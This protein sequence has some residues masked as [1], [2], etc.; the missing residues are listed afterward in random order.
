MSFAFSWP[1]AFPSAFYETARNNLEQ[2]MNAGSKL[3]LA[4]D[5]ILVQELHLGTI[6]PELDLLEINQLSI[7]GSFSGSFFLSYNGNAYISL[8]THLHVNPLS[9]ILLSAAKMMVQLT[10][11]QLR[12]RC[13]ISVAFS[14]ASGLTLVFKDDPLESLNVSSSFD[15]IGVISVFLQ[16][17]IENQLRERFRRDLPTLIHKLS[18]RWVA[19][20]N[21]QPTGGPSAP[22][23]VERERGNHSSGSGTDTDTDDGG[24]EPD[25]DWEPDDSLLDPPPHSQYYGEGEEERSMRAP[26]PAVSS[27][28][29]LTLSD[30]EEDGGDE[31][32][33]ASFSL[34][35]FGAPTSQARLG[36]T[37]PRK[38]GTIH[39][40]VLASSPGGDARRRMPSAGS[41]KQS[42][43][44]RPRQP[45]GTSVTSPHLRPT[46]VLHSPI[47]SGSAMGSSTGHASPSPPVNAGSSNSEEPRQPYAKTR[48]PS[49]SA[50]S[51]PR[52]HPTERIRSTSASATTSSARA[53]AETASDSPILRSL[54]SHRQHFATTFSNPIE[55]KASTTG[56]ATGTGAGA[57]EDQADSLPDLASLLGT[58]PGAG[59]GADAG[60]SLRARRRRIHRLDTP[61]PNT[62]PQKHGANE[63]GKG[64]STGRVASRTGDEN[65]RPRVASFRQ[66]DFDEY[67]PV[68]GRDRHVEHTHLPTSASASPVSRAVP[69]H[70]QKQQD[71][72]GSDRAAAAAGWGEGSRQRS[73]STMKPGLRRNMMS[74]RLRDPNFFAPNYPG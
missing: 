53:E 59:A 29:D 74:S 54:Q 2:A 26:S 56:T 5:R 58:S 65:A 64:R 51:A 57:N 23:T 31:G 12:L 21:N 30:E 9:S 7:D 1:R 33:A 27:D 63:K 28:S 39:A 55:R 13:V 41:P 38:E 48:S 68:S 37:P 8:V 45:S 47:A 22:I 42:P 52:R 69:V 15:D 34:S 35:G 20:I 10:L 49:V 61:S 66:A 43:L 50:S 11:S 16:R 17:E 19:D 72:F 3:P 18:Q 14:K 24:R 32:R 62:S 25:S 71:A 70:K 60:G 67:F 40:A 36:S 4:A 73:G 44:L 46:P 6:P